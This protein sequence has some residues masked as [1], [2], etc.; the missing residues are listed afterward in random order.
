[1]SDGQAQVFLLGWTGDFGDPA[2][3]D[4]VHFG[5]FNTQF[6]FHNS[7]L[8]TMLKNADS[9]TN[10]AKR[11]KDYQA[12]EIYIMKFL[13]VVPYVHTKPALAFQKNVV[14]YIPSPVSLEPFSTVSYSK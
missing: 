5:Q 7:K 1:V 9:E 2:N 8:F 6:G 12:A 10:N 4:N 14:G 13:P 11:V 3:F